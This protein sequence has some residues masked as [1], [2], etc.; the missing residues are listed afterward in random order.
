MATRK[1]NL[2]MVPLGSDQDSWIVQQDGILR[3][4]NKNCGKLPELPQ[5]GDIIVSRFRSYKTA[6]AWAVGVGVRG[7]VTFSSGAGTI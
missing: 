7:E 2:S 5:E 4:N 3:H 1:S 6:M